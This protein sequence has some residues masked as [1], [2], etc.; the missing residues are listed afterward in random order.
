MRSSS[1]TQRE[2]GRAMG[3]MGGVGGKDTSLLFTEAPDVSLGIQ[4]GVASPL[5]CTKDCRALSFSLSALT[6]CWSA[7][8]ELILLL[9]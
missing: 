1:R 9:S 3:H 7:R 4:W 6:P 5:A 2:T 8:A